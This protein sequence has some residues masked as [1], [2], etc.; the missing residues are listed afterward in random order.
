VAL[1]PAGQVDSARLGL[2]LSPVQ[3]D[4]FREKLRTLLDDV[5]NLPDD[6]TAPAWSVF[7]SIHPDPNRP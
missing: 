7:L 4:E 5:A 6:P 3:M 1:V 2:R